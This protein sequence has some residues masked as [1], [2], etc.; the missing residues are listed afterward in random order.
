[1]SAVP[2]IFKDHLKPI[3]D[4]LV[5]LNENCLDW[6]VTNLICVKAKVEVWLNTSSRRFFSYMPLHV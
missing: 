1:M 2:Y 6:K 5:V 4:D 3:F